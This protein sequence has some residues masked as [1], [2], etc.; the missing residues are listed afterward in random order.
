MRENIHEIE[1]RELRNKYRNSVF[2]YDFQVPPRH[3]FYDQ[4]MLIRDAV[5]S[6][7]R[8]QA[9]RVA[10]LSIH[11]RYK[12]IMANIIG[13]TFSN[14]DQTYICAEDAVD[15]RVTRTYLTATNAVHELQSQ[16]AYYYQFK[17]QYGSLQAEH[18]QRAAMIRQKPQRYIS[19]D[20][21]HL[22][23]TLMTWDNVWAVGATI[24]ANERCLYLRVGLCNIEMNESAPESYYEN[25][26]AIRLAPF[27]VT[28]KLSDTGK[29][30]CSSRN[31]QT[32]GLSRQNNPGTLG[33]DIHPH[34]LSDQPCFGT[35]GQTLIDSASKGDLLSYVAALIGF[36][37][38][39]NS[40]DSAGI[41]AQMF[42]PANMRSF[43]SPE[44]Y[45]SN[46]YATLI[47]FNEVVETDE[48]KIK[49]AIQ[50]YADYHA[51]EG[52]EQAP[53]AADGPRC[54]ACGDEP[55]GNDAD[56]YIPR[57]G[58][59]VCPSCWE[60]HYCGDCEHHMEDCCC[61]NEDDGAY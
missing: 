21:G 28:V 37:S 49:T 34:Q 25:P 43:E 11:P 20:T 42:H 30:I 50:D 18:N 5:H 12:R 14:R 56:Y 58:E 26:Q 2:Q 60:D 15:V 53:M 57:S 10:Y 41:S 33:Y 47:L 3:M 32:C 19:I 16:K 48:Q 38:Q 45:Y 35:Y 4:R 7:R 55:V 27:F 31:L 24:D 59:R 46:L 44:E 54:A 23:K 13:G 6:V 52:L 8:M 1:L 17:R 36:Y 9:M 51:T 61:E 22:T 29:A 40:Q 39:Y